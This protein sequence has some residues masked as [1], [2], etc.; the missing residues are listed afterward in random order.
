MKSKIVVMCVVF[1]V[2]YGSVIVAGTENKGP[3][4]ITLD[5]GQRGMV[6]FPHRQHQTTLGNC[7]IC[8]NIF[9]QKLGAIKDLKNQGRLAKKQVMNH[10]YWLMV[11]PNTF[12]LSAIRH[13]QNTHRLIYSRME[14]LKESHY[15]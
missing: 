8:H 9:P 1:V 6:G 14:T 13:S 10:L 15:V 2:L 7:N 11:R 5:G 4:Q 3:E 12:M